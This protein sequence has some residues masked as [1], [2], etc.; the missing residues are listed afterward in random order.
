MSLLGDVSRMYLCVDTPFLPL[1]PM[2]QSER[3]QLPMRDELISGPHDRLRSSSFITV[4]KE[5]LSERFPQ[6]EIQVFEDEEGSLSVAI[7]GIRVF[8][9]GRIKEYLAE[10]PIPKSRQ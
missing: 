7:E 4:V 6:S 1:T 5:R 2:P 10:L 3:Y 8:N 9:W